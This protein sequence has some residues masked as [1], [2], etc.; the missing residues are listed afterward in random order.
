M[1]PKENAQEALETLLAILVLNKE[2]PVDAVKLLLL[3]RTPI[4]H[5]KAAQRILMTSGCA[6]PELCPDGVAGQQTMLSLNNLYEV[7][8]AK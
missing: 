2:T 6:T 5:V 3:G 4:P 7:A 8:N 1:N